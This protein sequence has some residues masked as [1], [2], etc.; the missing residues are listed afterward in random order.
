MKYTYFNIKLRKSIKI[1]EE[2]FSKFNRVAIAFSGG[3]D[4]LVCVYLVYK[5][6]RRDD[7]PVVFIDTQKHFP[8]TYEYVERLKSDTF[9]S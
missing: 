3:S 5:V 2:A 4:S 7:V 9:L 8:E 1:L 6:L